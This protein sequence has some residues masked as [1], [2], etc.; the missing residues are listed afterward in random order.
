MSN[1]SPSR[2]V[3]FAIRASHEQDMAEVQKLYAHHVLTGT[4]S[5]EEAPPTLDEMQARRLAVIAQSCPYLVAEREGIVVGYAYA[6]A[7]RTRSAYRF[8]VE[9]TVYLHPSAMRLGIARALMEEVIVQCALSGYRQMIA[10]IGDE[11]PA[12]VA[13]HAALGFRVVGRMEAVGFKF[14]R[15]LDTTLM[16]RGLGDGDGA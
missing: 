8:T 16:Q 4:A 12:S 11:N 15:W 2:T 10:V 3:P 6:G 14:G 13:F 1:S 9:N 5:F 7:F